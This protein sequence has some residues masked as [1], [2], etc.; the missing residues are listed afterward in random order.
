MPEPIRTHQWNWLGGVVVY[1]SFT[2]ITLHTE[3]D[4]MAP[5]AAT[6]N[7][8]HVCG[9][10]H[11]PK[12]ALWTGVRACSIATVWTVSQGPKGSDEYLSRCQNL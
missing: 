3:R 5:G 1:V 10:S 2:P 4:H 7:V 9:E 8:N 11:T 12:R 6:N